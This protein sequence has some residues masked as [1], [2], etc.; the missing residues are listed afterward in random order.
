MAI[1]LDHEVGISG[2][3]ILNKRLYSNSSLRWS[4]VFLRLLGV[5]E[6]QNVKPPE[7]PNL[8]PGYHRVPQTPRRWQ[9]L[10]AAAGAAL[11]ASTPHVG[12]L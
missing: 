12:N 8:W 5:T 11:G 7:L 10:S 2:H 6:K 3:S 9:E 1:S 4:Q